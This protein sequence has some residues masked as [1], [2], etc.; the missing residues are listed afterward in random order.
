MAPSRPHT[1]SK[2]TFPCKQK[3]EKKSVHLK[4]KV[5][6]IFLTFLLKVGSISIFIDSVK[7]F[8]FQF[9]RILLIQ[10]KLNE[11]FPQSGDDLLLGNVGAER[12]FSKK[13]ETAHYPTLCNKFHSSLY[14]LFLFGVS[15]HNKKIDGKLLFI[16][17]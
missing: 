16:H 17:G 1:S 6:I 15:L 13:C 2:K 14:F 12:C 7:G 10:H 5:F 11:K 3:R 8:I 9:A 4:L